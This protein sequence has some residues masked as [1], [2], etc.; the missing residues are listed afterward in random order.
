MP[1]KKRIVKVTYEGGH[2]AQ[3]EMPAHTT[4]KEIRSYYRIGRAFN[5][6]SIYDSKVYYVKNVEI[7]DTP[8]TTP[9][10]PK[11]KPTPKPKPPK[12]VAPP[13]PKPET[14][15]EHSNSID[16]LFDGSVKNIDTKVYDKLL[17]MYFGNKKDQELRPKLVSGTHQNK[18]Y[19][20]ATNGMSVI[21][22]PLP[23]NNAYKGINPK[24]EIGVIRTTNAMFI[25]MKI[26]AI[27]VDKYETAGIKCETLSAEHK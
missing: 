2:T 11:T 13:P 15:T 12:S 14:N 10:P 3:V 27:P 16:Y 7:L 23:K 19:I 1:A 8:K 22:L 9:P 4:D 20:A 5:L 21:I 25:Q 18:D 24:N 17:T 6:G 26:Y